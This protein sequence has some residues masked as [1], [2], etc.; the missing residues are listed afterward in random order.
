MRKLIIVSAALAAAA[1]VSSVDDAWAKTK[2]R[3]GGFAV[4]AVLAPAED[5]Q[6]VLDGN[7]A[8]ALD[9]YRRA[10]ATPG[11]VVVSPISISTALA[12]SMAAA[13]GSTR[14]QFAA[15]LH[16]PLEQDALDVAYQS[17]LADL[18][19]E[20]P[21][22]VVLNV[23]NALWISRE[24]SFRRE[25]V[26]SLAEHY[27]ARAAA[28]PFRTAHERSRQTINRWCAAQTRGRIQGIL[29]EGTIGP[30]TAFVLTNA[31]YLAAKW[32]TPFLKA[33]TEPREFRRAQGGTVSVPFMRRRGEMPWHAAADFD[34]V[35]LPYRGGDYSMTFLVPRDGVALSAVEASLTP[36]TITATHAAVTTEDIVFLLPKFRVDTSLDLVPGLKAAGVLDAFS[37]A[38]ADFSRATQNPGDIVLARVLHKAVLRV[39]ELGTEAAAATFAT[40]EPT[41]A[42]PVII[43]NRPFLFLLRHRPTG[44]ILFMGRVADPKQ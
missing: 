3:R 22:G 7:A 28:L 2:K 21:K 38:A 8:F 20:N 40:Y 31:V 26:D 13:Q 32:E 12:M 19:P 5:R 34:A 30:D 39:D 10:A 24:L 27:A 15:A 33:Y 16:L 41:S 35:E 11:N 36:E 25:F 6:T 4:R 42:P 1:A 17:V 44:T 23:A 18:A 29:E 37:P 9:T 14:D 43:A